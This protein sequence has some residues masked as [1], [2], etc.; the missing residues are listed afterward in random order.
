M[1][2]LGSGLEVYDTWTHLLFG[3]VIVVG[4]DSCWVGFNFRA[5]QS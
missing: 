4:S 2:G 5:A 1:L 3:R